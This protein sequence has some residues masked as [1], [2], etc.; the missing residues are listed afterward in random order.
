MKLV[1]EVRVAWWLKAYLAGLQ[2]MSFL[3]DAEPDWDKVQAMI[4]RG[5]RVSI[6]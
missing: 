3:M 2:M 4:G 5:I 6:K 1:L